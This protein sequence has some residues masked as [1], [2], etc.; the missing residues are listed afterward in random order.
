[1]FIT[2]AGTDDLAVR[3]DH[4]AHRR[5]R[6]LEP[7]RPERHAGLRA[8][9]AAAEDGLDASDTRALA[10]QGCRVP[11]ATCSGRAARASASS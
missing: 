10:F 7:H 2:N 1:M 5:G 6:D 9:P 4:R 3:H 11:E 8:R